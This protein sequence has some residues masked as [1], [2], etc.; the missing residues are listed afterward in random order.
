MLTRLFCLLLLILPISSQADELT[1]KK[2]ED[3]TKLLVTTGGTKIGVQ[4]ANAVTEN[5]SKTL[6][7]ARPDIPDRVFTVLNQ[8]MMS[9]MQEKMN[10]PGGMIDLVIPIYDKHF[11]HA[12]IKELLAFYQTRIGRKSIEVLPMVVSESMQVGQSWGQSLGPEIAQRVDAVLK[13]EGIQMP[14]TPPAQ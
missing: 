4:F 5:L 2:R 8:E 7:A 11:T 1:Q 3:I 9:L 10:A 6:K 13:K 14:G 12:D